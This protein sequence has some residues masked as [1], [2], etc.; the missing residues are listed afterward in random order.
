[1]SNAEAAS[2]NLLKLIHCDSCTACSTPRY[3]R[4]GYGLHVTV[5][6]CGPCQLDVCHNPYN[7]SLD[8]EAEDDFSL[9][10]TFLIKMKEHEDLHVYS[11]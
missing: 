1:M 7:K 2:S 8:S 3:T 10:R 5:C 6:V 11:L 9:L 4:R